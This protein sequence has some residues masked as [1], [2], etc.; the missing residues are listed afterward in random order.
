LFAL[1]RRARPDEVVRELGQVRARILGVQRLQRLPDAVV[2]AGPPGRAKPIVERVA[3]QHV[4][5]AHATPRARHLRDHARHGRLID[6]RQ[7]ESVGFGAH[8]LQHVQRKLPAKHGCLEKD[9]VATRGEVGESSGDHI[10]DG[11]RD[12]QPVR[13][14]ELRWDAFERKQAYGLRD[15]QR[16]A[17]GLR[18]EV[19]AEEAI[20][21]AA[22]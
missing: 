14:A 1:V 11:L 3:D 2:K 7:E 19:S 18:A 5:E 6:A 10:A 15:E 17:L 4:R 16:V 9:L 8:P 12:R 21:A 20:S 22:S 13:A